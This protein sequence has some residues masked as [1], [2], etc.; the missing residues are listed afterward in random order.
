[1][2]RLLSLPS[3]IAREFAA[4]EPDRARDW[5]AGSDPV[6]QNLGS[7]GGTAHLLLEAWRATG[8]QC[9]F[10]DWLRQSQKL[11][12]HAGGEGRRLPAYAVSGKSLIPMPVL[13]WSHGQRLDQTLLDLQQTAY[14]SIFNHAP[15]TAR[16]MITT[17]DVLLRYAAPLPKLPAVDVLAMGLWVK[18]EHASHHGV[19]FC[20][21]REPNQL[22]FF[23]QKPTPNHIRELGEDYLFLVDVGVWM[24]SERAVNVLMQK[25]ANEGAVRKYELFAEFGLGLGAQ[26]AQADPAVNALTTAVVPLPQGEFYHFGTSRELIES[27]AALHNVVVDQ[28]RWGTATA[29]LRPDMHLLNC[30][31]HAGRGGPHTT[32]WVENSH[33]PASWTVAREH[34]LTG[35]P[36]ND[37]ELKLEPGICLDFL[38]IG[39]AELCL[40]FYGIDDPF[41]GDVWLGRP[42]SQWFAAR[43]LPPVTGDLQQAP[44][45]PVLP[46]RDWTP[47]F[48]KWLFAAQPVTDP[49]LAALWQ[50]SP[51]L[52]A[53]QLMEQVNLQRLAAQRGQ[54]RERMFAGLAQ[55]YR[56]SVF[57]KLDLE[58]TARLYAATN[59][60][61]PAELPA[62]AAIE[63][64]Q[65]VQDAMFRAAVLR[66][67]QVPAWEQHEARAFG[68]LR[69][70]IVRE[71]EL[72]PVTPQRC[73]LDDQIVWGRSPLRLDLAGGWTDTPP[74]CLQF[75]GK[76]VNAA[77]D[78]NGQPPIQVFAR[79]CARPELVI[80]SI[81]IGVEERVRTFAELATFDQ[82]G[83]GFTIAK[84]ALALAGFLPRFNANSAA[85]LEQ[86]LKN[87][88]G[89]IEVSLLSAVPKGSGLGT[90]S[91]LAATLLGTLSELCGLNWS[92]HDL[93]RRTLALEQ[94]LTTGGGW[95]DQ[96]GGILH[97][98]K[99]IETEA[100]LA[101]TPTVRWL[102]GDFLGNESVL[103]YYTGITRVAADILREI[104]R[105][106]F[107]NA[108]ATLDI[109][110]EIGR[111][112]AVTADILQRHDW[113]NFGAAIATSWELNQRLDAG[114]N[115]PAVQAILAQVSDYLA[116]AK[117][118]G[119]G[120]GGFMLMIAKDDTAAHRIRTTL[121]DRPP[122]AKARFVNLRLS[123]TGLQV[124]RS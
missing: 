32:M 31:Y 85:T 16:V 100:G 116:G 105:R 99:L 48:I 97:G 62:G 28:T 21:R 26:P 86:Q 79:V 60:E 111:H 53:R 73:V 55:N 8:G 80:R 15:A 19:F 59:L 4:L 96:V 11:I 78:L 5:F 50:N 69:E 56:Q 67:R 29:T 12:I 41:R 61:L 57:Y 58:A 117:L 25:C 47:Q 108:H 94:L 91:I 118:L 119:A 74:Y 87:F 27:V 95:Q 37:W 66:R 110:G 10:T 43:N 34:L 65:R 24:L 54:N 77:A 1:M 104:V 112:A 113:N 13:R 101:Q 44:L 30:S 123:A 64:L 103:L 92:E 90:S 46:A 107:L 75:G 42:V 81:D 84:A 76:V 40:R 71:A 22:A 115:P 68:L 35:V 106:M 83:S 124:T 36:V 93:F 63:P 72:I 82:I 3:R 122:N 20:P 89:G 114:T 70:V 121:T 51:R 23:L 6:G 52:S 39:D 17:G 98:L 45:F 7:G 14:E 102:P 18:P 88:G 33:I 120:G 109:V 2:Q 49:V 38:P 9:P